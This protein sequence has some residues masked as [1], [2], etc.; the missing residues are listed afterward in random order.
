R[1]SGIE[2]DKREDFAAARQDRAALFGKETG[3]EVSLG[4]RSGL[5]AE[6]VD[7]AFGFA[8][9]HGDGLACGDRKLACYGQRRT[10]RE[11]AAVAGGGG[12]AGSGGL[13]LR[14]GLVAAC[15][16][17]SPHYPRRASL[18]G[19]CGRTVSVSVCPL[20]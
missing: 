3:D 14:A 10:V 12:A 15:A 16:G 4:A 9:G 1:A 2:R 20:A 19:K 5:R 13:V 7:D 8:L 6:H 18:A 17:R 11:C